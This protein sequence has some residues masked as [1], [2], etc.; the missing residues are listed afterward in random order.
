[1]SL[2]STSVLTESSSKERRGVAN[3]F[4][5]SAASCCIS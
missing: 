3:L 1:M 4:F 5:K 2:S